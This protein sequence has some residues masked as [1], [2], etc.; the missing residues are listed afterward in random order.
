M[1]SRIMVIKWN[2]YT[3]THIIENVRADKKREGKR[4]SIIMRYYIVKRIKQ[5]RE[6]YVS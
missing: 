1:M 5:K 2:Q 4:F 6:N 3:S